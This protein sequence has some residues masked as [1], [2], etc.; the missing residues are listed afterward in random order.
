MSDKGVMAKLSGVIVVCVTWAVVYLAKATWRGIYNFYYHPLAKFPGPRLAAVSNAPYSIWFLGGRQPYKLL[1]LHKKYGPVVRIAPNELSFN[2]TQAWKDIHGFRPGHKTFIKS[3]F[4]DGGS[5]A[6]RVHSIVSERDPTAHGEMRRFLAHAFSDHSLL[7]QEDLIAKTVDRFIEQVGVRGEKG[8]DFCKGADMMTFDVIGDLAF[9]ETFGGVETCMVVLTQTISYH[10][11]ELIVQVEPHPWIST[12]LGALTKGALVDVFGR[13]PFVASIVMA[14]FPG[15][16]NSLI[17]QTKKNEEM[18]FDLIKRR[19][20]KKTPRKDFM[21]RI[22]EQRDPNLVSDL[23]LSAHASDMVLAGSETPSTVVSCVM[24]YL[25]NCPDVLGE[26][27]REIRGAFTEYSQINAQSTAGLK[28]LHNVILEA[29]RIYPPVPFGIPRVVPEGGDT[30]DG[31]L[32]PEGTIV[33]TNPIAATLDPA[34]FDSPLEFRPNRWQTGKGAEKSTDNL[35]ASQPFSLGARGCIGRSL[36]WMETRTTLAKL[37]F[38]YDFESLNPD[39][40]W[41]R[42]SRMNTLWNK[43]EFPIRARRRAGQPS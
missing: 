35:E 21:T 26:F 33:Q 32:L 31:H 24:Y 23:Q 20:A 17:E 39:L 38:M 8:F 14:L 37:H 19:I 5:F 30:V 40:D 36:G 41:H 9:G 2:S 1:D 28:Y 12:M 29:L 22:L 7:E 16:I 15:K 27:Q 25:L 43:P 42:D 3:D 34:N 6:D 13:F 18:A 10:E 4:Y 11:R